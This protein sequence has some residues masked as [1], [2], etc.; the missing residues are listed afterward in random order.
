MEL[1]EDNKTN[2]G[3]E[4]SKF[5][6]TYNAECSLQKSSSA[7]EDKIWLGVDDADPKIM[8]SDAIEL[9]LD[10]P[11]HVSTGWIHYDIQKEVLLTT[12]MHLNIEQVKQLLPYLQRFVETGDL[13]E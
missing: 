12:R 13:H 6:D 9:G 5:K 7:M 3:F 2:R 1:I 10:V 11:L 4:I 8:A